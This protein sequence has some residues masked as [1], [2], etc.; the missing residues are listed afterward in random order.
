M[1]DR[2]LARL[3]AVVAMFAAAYSASIW[4]G[5]SATISGWAG[6]EKHQSEIASLKVRAAG[7]L[8]LAISL[9]FVSALLLGVRKDK[10]GE[11]ASPTHQRRISLAVVLACLRG[12]GRR[13]LISLLGTLGF[14]VLLFSIGWIMFVFGRSA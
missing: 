8:V 9:Q 2:V 12:Y 14:A 3:L 6:I 7:W 4:L 5:T 13:V 1:G 10:G 11:V